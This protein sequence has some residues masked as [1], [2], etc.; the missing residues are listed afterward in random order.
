MCEVDVA[1]CLGIGFNR[2]DD[3]FNT[4]HG[5]ALPFV[6]WEL[7]FQNLVKLPL[8]FAE[9]ETESVIECT[10]CA[11]A[12][13]HL[14]FISRAGDTDAVNAVLKT[15]ES[16]D[17]PGIGVGA[18]V[19]KI[20]II[21]GNVALD[22][23]YRRIACQEEKHIRSMRVT[24]E[25][26]TSAI[27]DDRAS[28]TEFTTFEELAHFDIAGCVTPL[29]AEVELD[30]VFFADFY[31][32]IGFFHRRT[33]RFIAIDALHTVFR[34]ELRDVGMIPRTCRDADNI[35]FLRNNHLLIV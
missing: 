23:F 32:G 25:G 33:Q 12:T 10:H 22:V 9:M 19:L 29:R 21:N 24:P 7:R 4:T 28:F 27:S 26:G 3:I 14:K 17:D 11:F 1:L 35:R 15:D 16:H 5:A 8:S 20:G 18:V 13:V 30:V 2:I 6:G 31:H 34:R